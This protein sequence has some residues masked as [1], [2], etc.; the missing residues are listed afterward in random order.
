MNAFK[1]QQLFGNLNSIVV[2]FSQ[3]KWIEFWNGKRQILFAIAVYFALPFVAAVVVM[4]TDETQ[5]QQNGCKRRAANEATNDA[6]NLT[7]PTYI[8]LFLHLFQYL[9]FSLFL[10]VSASCACIA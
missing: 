4:W 5:K 9:R 10:S 8:S 3:S 6:H 7:L 1:Y 2:Y